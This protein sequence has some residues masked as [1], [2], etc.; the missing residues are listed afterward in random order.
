MFSRGT[1][2]A[3]GFLKQHPWFHRLATY[4]PTALFSTFFLSISLPWPTV[5]YLLLGCGVLI[6]SWDGG[7]DRSEQLPPCK[8]L[9][10]PLRG[11]AFAPFVFIAVFYAV[12]NSMIVTLR[13][14][15]IRWRDTFY[16]LEVLRA[17]MCF[18]LAKQAVLAA[19][20]PILRRGN[21]RPERASSYRTHIL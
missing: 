16:P 4:A 13:Q 21:T 20:V 8:R 11:A 15:G 6:P 1:E 2:K 5:F 19:V 9:G 7:L 10:W 12:L 18:R 3:A 14:Q 17:G